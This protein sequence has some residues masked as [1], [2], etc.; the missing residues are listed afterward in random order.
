V[1]AALVNAV[2]NVNINELKVTK[3]LLPYL[4]F[5]DTDYSRLLH[6]NNHKILEDDNVFLHYQER[7]LH[8][9]SGGGGFESTRW[10]QRYLLPTPADAAVAALRLWL[11]RHGEG[12]GAVWSPRARLP[13]ATA[14]AATA[15]TA[16]ATAAAPARGGSGDG[17]SGARRMA[18]LRLGD[19]P[20]LPHAALVERR[21]SHTAHCAPCA[22]A[23]AAAERA[24]RV[25]G[26]ANKVLLALAVLALS[27]E[28][29][30]SAA[31]EAPAA[32]AV[33]A[34]ASA[35]VQAAAQQVT[36]QLTQGVYP[37][38]RNRRGKGNKGRSIVIKDQR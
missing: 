14:A 19:A 33:A 13:G 20:P 21:R 10:R 36:Q 1:A 32:L 25:G 7:A 29:A 34:L 6:V 31:A 11:E 4:I 12:G 22:A 8:G 9:G 3:V 23:L 15:A 5:A 24:E 37:P 27:A 16:A 28:S 17:G 30:W 26:A 18:P 38:P 2:R 35:A